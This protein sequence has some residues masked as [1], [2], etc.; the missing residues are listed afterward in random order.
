MAD[1]AQAC[2]NHPGYQTRVRCSA[3]GAPICVRCMQQTPVGMKCPSCA[4]L[5]RRAVRMGK[6]RHYAAA[7]AAGLGTAM[8]LG[9]GLSLLRLRLFGLLLPILAGVVVGM[10]VSAAA[11]RQGHRPFQLIAAGATFV[12]L[13][14]GAMLLGIPAAA[15]FAPIALLGLFVAAVVAAFVVSR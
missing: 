4:R 6:P 11:S 14:L 10:A 2:V 12:G 13:P 15:A 7:L 8:A 3:C 1:T 9:A 5:P